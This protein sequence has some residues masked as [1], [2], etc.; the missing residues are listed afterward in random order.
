MI[1]AAEATGELEATLDD[2]ANYYTEMENTRKQM[3]SAISYP[4]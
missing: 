2:M 4:L 3:I 1:K